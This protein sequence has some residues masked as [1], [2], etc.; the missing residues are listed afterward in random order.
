[1]KYFLA[2]IFA[3]VGHHV[4][5]Q[6]SSAKPQLYP[7]YDKIDYANLPDDVRAEKGRLFFTLNQGQYDDF[8]RSKPQR[9]IKLLSKELFVAKFRKNKFWYTDY[10][11][12][13]YSMTTG[14]DERF[15][16]LT[17]STLIYV[18]AKRN[19]RVWSWR[20]FSRQLREVSTD[21]IYQIT[22]SA[23]QRIEPSNL[24]YISYL[25]T[26]ELTAD[27]RRGSQQTRRSFDVSVMTYTDVY[28]PVGFD[29]LLVR[30]SYIHN[31]AD[32]N[33]MYVT[34]GNDGIVLYCSVK[35][36]PH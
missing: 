20:H 15:R 12:L 16:T 5:A 32:F 2:C 14:V 30:Q 3:V 9:V 26:V 10:R 25:K 1:M 24:K 33:N 7:V 4:T 21:T 6:V 19:K 22:V 35:Q 29:E 31:L 36:E 8:A 11:P 13:E 17:D 34:I 27:I 18:M 23:R 28:L